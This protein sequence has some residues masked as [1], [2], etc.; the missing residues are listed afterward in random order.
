MNG[1]G[2]SYVINE[3][4]TVTQ[5]EGEQV[6]APVIEVPADPINQPEQPQED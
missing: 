6:Q 3:D 5:V 2:G 4:Q 1:Q